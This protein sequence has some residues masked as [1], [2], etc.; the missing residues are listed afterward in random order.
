MQVMVAGSRSPVVP[1]YGRTTGREA[2]EWNAQGTASKHG[3]HTLPC[4]PSNFTGGSLMDRNRLSGRQADLS[5]EQA[6]RLPQPH[7]HRPGPH[8]AFA[9][10]VAGLAAFAAVACLPA[11]MPGM[12]SRATGYPTG[13]PPRSGLVGT[14]EDTPAPARPVDLFDG[15][16]Y[17][18]DAAMP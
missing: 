10:A 12:A 11:P 14:D 9:L 18:L 17:P 16:Y 1:H 13:D 5:V 15:C 8:R 3:L 4:R 2:F 7:G 6:P